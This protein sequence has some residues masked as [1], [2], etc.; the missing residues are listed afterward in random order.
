[1]HL[2]GGPSAVHVLPWEQ[3]MLV[4]VPHGQLELQCA[5]PYLPC[6]TCA[7]LS[8]AQLIGRGLE[9][10][11]STFTQY[12]EPGIRQA[13]SVSGVATG[14]VMSTVTTQ[15][16][17]QPSASVIVTVNVSVPGFVGGKEFK[18]YAMHC[19]GQRFGS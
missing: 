8:N 12:E 1:M 11:P 9:S 10:F 7:S 14:E 2:P 19:P 4:L 6:V 15:E 18:V 16:T 13:S 17:V 3:L 5:E